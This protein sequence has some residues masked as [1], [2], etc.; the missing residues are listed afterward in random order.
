MVDEESTHGV[1]EVLGCRH[2]DE[3]DGP[4]PGQRTDGMYEHRHA[5]EQPQRLG[6]PRSES[7]AAPR[8]GNDGGGG[9]GATRER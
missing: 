2:H 9:H 3:V 7:F 6:C 1:E 4:G 8:G 5:A